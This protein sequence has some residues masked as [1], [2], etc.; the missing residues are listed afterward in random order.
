MNMLPI[1]RICVPLHH[2]SKRTRHIGLPAVAGRQRLAGGFVREERGQREHIRKSPVL[3]AGGD[4]SRKEVPDIRFPSGAY[5]EASGPVAVPDVHHRPHSEVSRGWKDPERGGA[6]GRCRGTSDVHAR[7][8]TIDTL[9]E[10]KSQTATSRL[11]FL[12]FDQVHHVM[13]R[14]VEFG[15]LHRSKIK[16]HNHIHIDEKSVHGRDFASILYDDDGTVLEVV[17]GRKKEDAKALIN[18][19]L[20]TIQQ[21]NVLTASIDMWDPFRD[22]VKELMPM[23]AICH[24][25]FHL[26]KH[27]NAAVD[28]VRR[29]EVKSNEYLKRTRYLFLKDTAKFTDKQQMKF[30]AIVNANYEVSRAWRIKEDFRDIIRGK[31]DRAEALT[32]YMMW[33]QR[34]LDARIPEITKVIEMF[35]RHEKG[36][37][38]ALCMG[39][40]NGK[41]ERMNGSI[42]ELQTVGRGYRDVER[43]RIA[44]L[45]F[46][47]GLTLHKD[48]LVLNSLS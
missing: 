40:N 6:L 48:Y 11:L 46:Y 26:V 34:A 22:A 20:N 44:V 42:Q 28:A 18:K 33:R 2:G 4:S 31:M 15:L 47:G 29:R 36:I 3:E 35:D 38:N 5:M 23:A 32:L 7:K 16:S 1:E 24:D 19:A 27:L 43:F 39:R 41:A 10:T 12:T 30:D 13:E 8:K 37:I 45:F 14:A 9:L 21:A 25:K 17:G